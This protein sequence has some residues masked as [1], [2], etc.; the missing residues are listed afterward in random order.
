MKVMGKGRKEHTPCFKGF[1]GGYFYCCSFPSL[2][3]C[4]WESLVHMQVSELYFTCACVK[5]NSY[6]CFY[7]SVLHPLLMCCFPF[8]HLMA[9]VLSPLSPLN[10]FSMA[11][12]EC[13]H[14]SETSQ[15][16]VLIIFFFSTRDVSSFIV[17]FKTKLDEV[18]LTRA[19]LFLSPLSFP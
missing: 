16:C 1:F 8:F 17:L 2:P 5:T 15:T 3:Q 14:F 4:S 18:I 6:F 13:V 7:G 12:A 19:V 10:T 9:S 11:R